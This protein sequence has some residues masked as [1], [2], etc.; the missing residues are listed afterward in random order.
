M[1]F[2]ASIVTDLRL[3]SQNEEDYD[4]RSVLQGKHAG[5]AI[6]TYT[7]HVTSVDSQFY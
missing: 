4:Y 7:V 1:R 5:G 2:R 3:R 6:H